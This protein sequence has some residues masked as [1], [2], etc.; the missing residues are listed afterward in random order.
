MITVLPETSHEG[1]SPLNFLENK[2]FAPM[3]GPSVYSM[4]NLNICAVRSG[5]ILLAAQLNINFHPDI[6]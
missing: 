1:S 3:L 2:D 4:A 5:L 6:P